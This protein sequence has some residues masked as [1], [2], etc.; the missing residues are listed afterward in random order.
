VNYYQARGWP[1]VVES[2]TRSPIDHVTLRMRELGA[3]P[4]EMAAVGAVWG[5]DPV[6]DD[7]LLHMPDHELR[8]EIL[9]V[10]AE[11]EVGTVSEEE[12]ADRDLVITFRHTMSEAHERAGGTIPA[13]M[14]WI[15]GDPVRAYAMGIV[16]TDDDGASRSTL[17]KQTDRIIEGDETVSKLSGLLTAALTYADNVVP[18]R[19][20]T[21]RLTGG[22]S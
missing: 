21:G 14:A 5:L 6:E 12:A 11:Y 19:R 3:T 15:A 9:A 8:A 2:E 16:E 20:P 17:L 10:R 4:D 13:I 1:R 7:R 18:L 22:E